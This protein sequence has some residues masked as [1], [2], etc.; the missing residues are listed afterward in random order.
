[1]TM[2]PVVTITRHDNVA[3][4]RWHRPD[5]ANAFDEGLVEE[6][7]AATEQLAADPPPVLAL[8]GL[9]GRFCGGFD[10]TGPLS[11]RDLA[12]R[13]MRA[14]ELLSRV[15]AFP[16]LT[17]ACVTGPAYGLGADLV[18]ACDYR[19][20][21][22]RARFRFPGPRFGIV[23]GTH[24]LAARVGASRATDILMR[25]SVIGGNDAV[26]WGLLSH[27][28]EADHQG[29]FV[30]ELAADVADVPPHT[31]LT[32]LSVLRPKLAD[33][34]AAAIARSSHLGGLGDRIDSYR[35]RAF[36]GEGKGR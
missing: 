30:E 21:E 22:A 25:N 27:H 19:L 32:L 6:L 18:A 34:S 16:A 23:L 4:L 20:G 11:D 14:E 36:S 35:A 17:V 1:M 10:L 15:R 33:A 13:F 7:L 5:A 8:S 24:Q 28:V 31:R 2:H 12:W 3:W 9:G 26:A 29:P